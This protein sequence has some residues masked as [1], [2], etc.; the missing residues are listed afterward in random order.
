MSRRFWKVTERCNT[1]GLNLFVII[2]N[3]DSLFTNIKVSNKTN[4]VLIYS[5]LYFMFAENL[6]HLFKP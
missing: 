3:L 5:I 6:Q 2:I 4:E 1:G